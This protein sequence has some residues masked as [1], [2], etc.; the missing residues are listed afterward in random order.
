MNYEIV[1]LEEK[2]VAGKRIRTSNSDPSMTRSIGELWQEFFA[3]GVY[4][5]IPHKQNDKSIG[6]Y[7][8]YEGDVHGPYDIMV[9]CEIQYSSSSPM[10]ID[11][12]IIPAGKYAKF[13]I[14]GDVQKAVADFW[15][16]LWSMDLDRK[17]SCDFE[18]YQ[19]GCNMDNAQI[20]VHIS[21]N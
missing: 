18:E 19:S 4:E 12:E 7:T 2:R 10:G 13:V 3:S 6:L 20:H 15:T 1:N 21:L 8:N 14:Q 17:Y 11:I 16:K 9:C 5:S